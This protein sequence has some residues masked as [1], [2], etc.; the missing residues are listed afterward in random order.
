MSYV[1]ADGYTTFFNGYD[2]QI[3]TLG[4]GPSAITVTAPNAGLASGQNVVI[5]GTVTDISA[6][7]QQTQQKA[8]FP[9]GVPVSS[10]ASMK[11]WMGYVYQ[12][13]PLPTNFTGVPVTIFVTDS[14]GNCYPIGTATTDSSGMYSLSW[15]P[16]ITGNFTV[17]ATFA[18]TAGYWPSSAETSFVVDPAAAATA[19]P[20]SAPASMVDQYFVPAVIG[21]ILAIILVG[22]A[23]ILLQRRHP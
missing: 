21:I 13:Q 4:R 6:G 16:T 9:N 17:T 7:T 14:N 20:T 18:G 22:V 2:G 11:D 19:A 15:K 10:D 8:D 1:I 3:Y 23:I 12:Q 5:R